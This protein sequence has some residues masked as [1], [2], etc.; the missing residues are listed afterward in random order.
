M[1]QRNLNIDLSGLQFIDS[2]GLGVMVRAKKFGARQQVD[3]R[4][5]NPTGNVRNVI[6]I[7]R[8]EDFL[9]N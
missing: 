2:T 8:L 5:S 3:V 1:V 6:R 9:L 4:F 7:S